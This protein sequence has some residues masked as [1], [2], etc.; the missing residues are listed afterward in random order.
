MKKRFS[1][2]LALA[3]ALSILGTS[4]AFGAPKAAKS[5]YKNG[6][7]S[8]ERSAFDNHG[9]YKSKVTITIANDK[10]TNAKY[11]AYTKDG[12]LKSQ[13]ASYESMMKAKEK[14]G[15]QEYQKLLTANLVKTNNADKV[16]V[17]TGAT[18]STNDFKQLV[19]AALE[20]AKK[21]VKTT[22]VVQ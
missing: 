20:N 18:Q 19:K 17:V 1:L 5:L 12:K 11:D 16:D 6:T 14:L 22:A 9:G 15:P 8:A 10:I 2:V 21:G 4:I 13:D 7:Y 3:F